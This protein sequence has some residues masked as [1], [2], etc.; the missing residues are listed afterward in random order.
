MVNGRDKGARYMVDVCRL[1]SHWVC[2][3][4]EDANADVLAFRPRST[5]LLPMEGHWDAKGDLLS[6]PALRFP[7]CVECKKHENG[8]LDGLLDAPK[9]AVWTWWEQAKEQ[10]SANRET[11]ALIFCRN[12][13]D[14]RLVIAKETA[15][16]LGL[17]PIHG[18]QIDITRTSGETLTLCL[19]ADLL[20]LPVGRLKRLQSTKNTS[21]RD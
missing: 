8:Y 15:T 11:P 13:R 2:G 19:L 7:L 6:R 4:P 16:C 17:K 18:P 10:A 12:Q 3:T 21:K 14:N 5:A 1:L 20:A 9:W